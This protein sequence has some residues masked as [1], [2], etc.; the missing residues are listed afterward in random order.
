MCTP[1]PRY[2]YPPVP[3]LPPRKEEWQKLEI[4]RQ[5]ALNRRSH[6]I[7]Q[8]ARKEASVLLQRDAKAKRAGIESNA[9]QEELMAAARLLATAPPREWG[10]AA[11]RESLKHQWDTFQPCELSEA[12][13]LHL[14]RIRQREELVRLDQLLKH[15]RRQA[16]KPAAL[17]ARLRARAARV[18]WA[19]WG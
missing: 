7:D 2:T 17:F 6:E 11:A 15:E 3:P 9:P 4:A 1:P 5:I 19:S 12:D 18:T 16:L 13:Q 8:R 10:Q 14:A